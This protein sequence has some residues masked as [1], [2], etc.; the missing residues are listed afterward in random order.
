EASRG[1]KMTQLLAWVS[2]SPVGRLLRSHYYVPA[3]V[4]ALALLTVGSLA[5]LLVRAGVVTLPFT[6]PHSAIVITGP[7]VSDDPRQIQ[8]YVLGAVA[9]PGVYAL[10]LGARVH[11]LI[12]SAG[13]ATSDADL[14]T[15]ALA[16]PLNDG[17]TVYV[18][19][20]GET[21]PLLLGGKINLNTADESG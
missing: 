10:S 9:S 1:A 15:V 19:H 13:G 6:Q 14:T 17:Q 2:A 20:A 3:A 4:L 16:A 12:A 21:P 8:A 7:G 11:D 5:G 18:P